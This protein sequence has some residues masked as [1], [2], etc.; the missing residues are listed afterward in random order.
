M[1]TSTDWAGRLHGTLNRSRID[2]PGLTPVALMKIVIRGDWLCSV[3]VFPECPFCHGPV[4]QC[5]SNVLS[6][7][8]GR[9]SLHMCRCPL[10]PYV[11][12]FRLLFSSFLW[13][14][15]AYWICLFTMDEYG[16][17]AT[18]HNS[19]MKVQGVALIRR[20]K[21][22]LLCKVSQQFYWRNSEE[23]NVSNY[24]VLFWFQ[25]ETLRAL[26]LSNV[27]Q[28]IPSPVGP[29]GLE[30]SVVELTRHPIR[31]PTPWRQSGQGDQWDAGTL[32][33]PKSHVRWV[34]SQG[35]WMMTEWMM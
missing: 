10:L 35:E 2:F 32:K 27:C 31:D 33:V 12:T 25:R 19:T 29:C 23:R 22:A 30:T 3:C 9:D 24:S 26:A 20:F 14:L 16:I 18:Q 13:V 5:P 17:C 15:E 11:V 28:S 8:G 1:W 34:C 21:D 4:W 6:A 7:Q